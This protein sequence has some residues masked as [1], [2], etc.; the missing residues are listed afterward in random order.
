[1]TRPEETV[2]NYVVTPELARTFDDALSFIKGALEANT[3]KACY[4]HGSFGSGKSHFM[5]MLHLILQLV[6][7]AVSIPELAWVIE[8]ANGWIQGKKFL[9][10]P[11]HMIGAR[12]M[13]AGILGGYADFIRRLHPEAPVPGVYL[14]EGL[15]ADAQDVRR[16]MGD[17][18]FF[19][20]LNEGGGGESDWGNSMPSGT[21]TV[22][23]RRSTRRRDRIPRTACNWSADW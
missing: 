18:A 10:V 6:L 9:L 3:S 8:K 2:S 11:Y 5:A 19:A 4:L 17:A 22:S 15:F 16:S 1:M 12:N 14:A 21:P 23:R 7:R 20:K 13:E